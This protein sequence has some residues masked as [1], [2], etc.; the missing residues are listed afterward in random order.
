[1]IKKLLLAIMIALP[2]MA[3]AQKFGYVDTQAIMQELP[4]IKD[5]QTQ[6]EASAQKYDAEGKN[7]QQEM[8]K[9]LKEFQE[10]DDKTPDAIRQRRAQ[11]LQDL[12]TKIQQFRQTA[13]QDLQRQQE[14][15]FAPIQQKIM[16]AIQS[17][18]KEGNYTMIFESNVP[19]YT[20]ADAVDLTS[21][22][23]AKLK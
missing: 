21:A 5:M 15:L 17:V 6:L 13:Q 1:M 7:L 14:Q 11:E 10:M 4:E 20:G 19:I 12:D 3:F 22:V 9:K 23:K 18:G 16:T 8:E 2:A